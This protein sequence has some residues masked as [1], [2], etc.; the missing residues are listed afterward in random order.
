MNSVTIKPSNKRSFRLTMLNPR[1][2][3]RFTCTVEGFTKV[4]AER[5]ARKQ[6]PNFSVCVEVQEAA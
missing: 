3:D 1:T 4:D 6:A 2:K 5:R